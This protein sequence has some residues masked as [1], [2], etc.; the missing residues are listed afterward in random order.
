MSRA[1]RVLQQ[2]ALG[3]LDLYREG[4]EGLEIVRVFFRRVNS[5][6][7]GEVGLNRMMLTVSLAPEVTRPEPEPARR[8][9]A[10]RAD[11]ATAREAVE[12]WRRTPTTDDPPQEL[13]GRLEALERA[14]AQAQTDLS[15]HERRELL[16]LLSSVGAKGAGEKAREH[17]ALVCAGV[18]SIQS[19]QMQDGELQPHPEDPAPEK[20]Q[21]L[22]AGSEVAADPDIGRYHVTLFSL[23]EITR[24]GDAIF[25]L[26]SGEAAGR[27]ALETFRQAAAGTTGAPVRGGVRGRAAR[28][29]GP[30]ADASAAHPAAAGTGG[31]SKGRAR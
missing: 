30:G 23:E 13:A 1:L 28:R 24:L 18:V 10:V 7:V 11:L 9:R 2:E 6:L 26:S 15:E 16:G 12:A 8:L 31:K 3:H 29:R 25:E 21:L 20:I 27:K 14:E 22:P 4:Q 17:E 5:R 19:M